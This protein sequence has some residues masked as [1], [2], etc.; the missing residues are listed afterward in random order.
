MT[1][2]FLPISMT[3]GLLSYA[4]IARWYLMPW[5]SKRSLTSALTPLLLFHSFRYIG[6]AFLI[7]GVTAESL[8]PRFAVPAA[9][10]DL[11]AALLALLSIA[12]LHNKW[13]L[14]IPVTWTFNV[15][16]L[17]DLIFA[18]TQGLRYTPD[19]DL[20]TMYLVPTLVV[21]ALIV[22]HILIFVVLARNRKPLAGPSVH[23]SE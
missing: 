18:V 9:Y 17:V 23:L 21:P 6:L 2:L 8:D 3:I 14:A 11:A 20:G 16:G 1:S 15:V 13:R 7:P 22:T 4:L 19:G 5:L 10:G 12:L